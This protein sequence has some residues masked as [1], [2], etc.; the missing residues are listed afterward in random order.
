MF[1]C[2]MGLE[3][4]DRL[5]FLRNH[6]IALWDVL[7]SADRETSLD[8]GIKNPKVND[9]EGF[10]RRHPKLRVICLNG[11][12]AY[13]YFTA[14]VGFYNIPENIRIISLPSTSSSNT[15]LTIDQKVNRW[16]ELKY[17]G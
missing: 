6:H 8:S 5:S 16:K 13:R 9:V 10:I 17:R 7:Q 4:Q 3:Y 2:H 12:E 11:N 1:G 14:Y 15:H